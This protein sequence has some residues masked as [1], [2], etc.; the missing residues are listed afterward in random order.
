MRV[1][2]AISGTDKDFISPKTAPQSGSTA[3]T[4]ILLGSRLF[5]ANVGDSRVVLCRGGAGQCL[6]LTSDHK[7]RRPGEAARVR[8]GVGF[9]LHNPVIGELLLLHEP[10]ATSRS[11]WAR[12]QITRRYCSWETRTCCTQRRARRGCQDPKGSNHSRS[13]KPR[14]CVDPGHC[15]AAALGAVK[16]M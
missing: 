5:A 3:A 6:E 9:I 11:R 8:A 4:V 2:T 13:T 1:L 10:L 16:F 7:P 12:F 14:Q 15:S